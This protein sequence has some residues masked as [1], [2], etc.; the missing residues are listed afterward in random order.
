MHRK[1]TNPQKDSKV[2]YRTAKGTKKINIAPR[3]Q[4]G[5]IRL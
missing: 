5:G 4:R 1:S 2:F 3:I